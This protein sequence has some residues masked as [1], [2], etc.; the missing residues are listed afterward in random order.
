MTIAM[1]VIA[2]SFRSLDTENQPVPVLMTFSDI[3]GFNMKK[4]QEFLDEP[5]EKGTPGKG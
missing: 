3:K 5:G 4:I 1:G 2:R